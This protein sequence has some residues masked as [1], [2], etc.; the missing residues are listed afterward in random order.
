MSVGAMFGFDTLTSIIVV[1][2]L[3][4]LLIC[5]MFF[6]FTGTSNLII[7]L[8]IILIGA[9][10]LWA[11]NYRYDQSRHSA[12]SECK[13]SLGINTITKEIMD[14][15]SDKGVKIKFNR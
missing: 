5:T 9:G 2:F 10:A 7:S 4:Y 6:A 1:I 14:C 8:A 15:M 11:W 12:L 3:L 13:K